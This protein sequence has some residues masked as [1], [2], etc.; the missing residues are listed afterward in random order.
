M[1]KEFN[2]Q[3]L[4]KLSQP[5]NNSQGEDNGQI[6]IIGGSELFHGA[7]IFALKNAS[8]FVD[9]VFFATPEKSVGYVAENM[10]SQL[11]SFIWVPWEET[12]EYIAKSDAIL[13]GSGF[14]RFASE[15]VSNRFRSDKCDEQCQLSQKTTKE[16]LTKFPSKKWVID[17]GSLQVMDPS[18]IPQNAVLTPNLKEFE[19]LFKLKP[20]S[21]NV[22]KVS[23]KYLCIIVLKS[24][25]TTVCDSNHCLAVKGGN[26][27]LT[28]G[29]TGDVQAGLTVALLA[30][31]DPFLAATSAAYLI[32]AAAD[33]LQKEMGTNYNSD[34][35]TLQ[36]PKTLN[37]LTSG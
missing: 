5:E 32:K 10:K 15:K 16:F 12:D 3:D 33:D 37:S 36:I 25:I 19:V 35:L 27:G 28:K 7:P 11:G 26:A 1:L 23:Q 31:N 13:I 17:A 9:M 4:K 24:V 6:T 34:D 20:T 21:E 8:R 2:P 30:K 22:Q 29:G 18:W 14:M